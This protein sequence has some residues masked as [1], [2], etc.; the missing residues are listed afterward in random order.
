[1]LITLIIFSS[2]FRLSAVVLLSSSF[3]SRQEPPASTVASTLT[4]GLVKVISCLQLFG[5]MT[6]PTCCPGSLGLTVGGLKRLTNCT[7]S[8]LTLSFLLVPLMCWWRL[9]IPI[10]LCTGVLPSLMVCFLRAKGLKLV[11]TFAATVVRGRAFFAFGLHKMSSVPW[12]LGAMA[13]TP[14]S[15]GSPV[16]LA[17][18]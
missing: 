18:S 9:R 11:S 7:L 4:S 6:T 5:V 16:S 14:I 15:L 13:R 8:W 2:L 1:M 10:V 12:K 3:L 17:G